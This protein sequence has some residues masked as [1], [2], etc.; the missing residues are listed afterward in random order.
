MKSRGG[1]HEQLERWQD[2]W[3]SMYIC[4]RTKFSIIYRIITG[5]FDND[6]DNVLLSFVMPE[7]AYI[8]GHFEV[9]VNIPSFYTIYIY[10]DY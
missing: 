1:L 10:A 7:G 3:N 8:A 9:I 5:N 4:V 6:S 2:S